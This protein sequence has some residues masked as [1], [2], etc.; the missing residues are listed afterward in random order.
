MFQNVSNLGPGSVLWLEH[1]KHELNEV[2]NR[3]IWGFFF[4]CEGKT[5]AVSDYSWAG[6][7]G[8]HFGL[9]F[10]LW[11]VKKHMHPLSVSR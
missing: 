9:V 8:C 11:C 4:P 6:T 7:K 5:R 10:V 1:L 2:F 3:N